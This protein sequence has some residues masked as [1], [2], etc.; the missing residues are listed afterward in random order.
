MEFQYERPGQKLAQLRYT[1][2]LNK[3]QFGKIFNVS[4][5]SVKNWE[6]GTHDYPSNVLR[7][8]KKNFHT[9]I[10]FFLCT[11]NNTLYT[12]MTNFNKDKKYVNKILRKGK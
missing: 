1:L 10:D 12:S 11:N 9:N 8:I 5:M 2:G 3:A 6:D 7:I 4:Y